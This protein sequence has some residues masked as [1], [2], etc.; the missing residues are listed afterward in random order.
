MSLM[1]VSQLVW[2]M[3]GVIPPPDDLHVAA[4]PSY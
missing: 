1:L 4:I 3:A 2:R